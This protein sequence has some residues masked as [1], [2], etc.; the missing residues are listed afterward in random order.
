MSLSAELLRHRSPRDGNFLPNLGKTLTHHQVL[1][2]T[3]ANRVANA[4]RTDFGKAV[5]SSMGGNP[6]AV[7]QAISGIRAKAVGQV[8]HFD[9]RQQL[10]AG[11]G[12]LKLKAHHKSLISH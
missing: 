7:N 9:R 11:L 4:P 12:A 8:S 10:S 6:R 2:A 3:M 1:P 5:L